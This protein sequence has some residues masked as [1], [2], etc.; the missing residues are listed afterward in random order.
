MKG[1][2]EGTDGPGAEELEAELVVSIESERSAAMLDREESEV[3]PP[4]GAGETAETWEEPMDENW[5]TH[6][7]DDADISVGTASDATDTEP[8]SERPSAS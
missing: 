2:T 3:P 6:D 1:L 8:L 7:V 5:S 4:T